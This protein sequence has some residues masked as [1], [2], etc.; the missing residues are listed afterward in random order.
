LDSPIKTVEIVLQ[1]LALRKTKSTKKRTMVNKEFNNRTTQLN[2]GGV[3]KTKIITAYRELSIE[4]LCVGKKF[5]TLTYKQLKEM[6]YDKKVTS[7]LYKNYYGW[8]EK[9]GKAEYIVSNIGKEALL[10]EKYNILIN[11]YEKEGL[12]TKY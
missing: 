6:G 3:N 11:Y 2:K 1:P 8:F 10:D 9:V 7:I 12:F 5:E 4:L